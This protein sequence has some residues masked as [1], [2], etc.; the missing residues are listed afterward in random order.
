MLKKWMLYFVVFC[1]IF[2]SAAPG[3]LP[4]YDIKTTITDLSIELQQDILLRTGKMINL[5]N[6]IKIDADLTWE[7]AL[8]LMKIFRQIWWTKF[9]E[10]KRNKIEFY[11]TN[12]FLM[13]IRKLSNKTIEITDFMFSMN[14]KIYELFFKKV[15]NLV[16]DLTEKEKRLNYLESNDS[17]NFDA[18]KQIKEE[19]NYLNQLNSLNKSYIKLKI[20]NGLK[21]ITEI[22]S[23]KGIST[24][25]DKETIFINIQNRY[26]ITPLMTAAARWDTEV[27]ET[28]LD[29][30]A[31]TNIQDDD[32][33]TALIEISKYYQPKM[34]EDLIRNGADINIQNK[35]RQTAL[36]WAS[37]VGDKETVRIL[38]SHGALTNLQDDYGSTALAWAKLNGHKGVVSIFDE[39]F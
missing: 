17:S 21:L 38:L 36:I 23:R 18:I 15:E 12:F 33:D 25:I 7:K 5:I 2:S 39:I 9:S 34:V 8:P 20:E 13:L 31:D 14:P 22:Q 35:R 24:K 28:L 6:A 19:L 26:G 4:E 29:N 37:M 11:F 16:K 10:E 30:N 32:G 3:T 27:M 1:K